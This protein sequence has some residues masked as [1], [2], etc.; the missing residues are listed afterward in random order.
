MRSTNLN[1]L[2]Q[3]KGLITTIYTNYHNSS[4]INKMLYDQSMLAVTE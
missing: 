4:L 2:S 1:L 3:V